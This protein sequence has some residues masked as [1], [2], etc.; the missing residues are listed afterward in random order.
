[1]SPAYRLQ[2][3]INMSCPAFFFLE[4]PLLQTDIHYL[5][6]Q[7]PSIFD[8]LEYTAIFDMHNKTMMVD[9]IY[10]SHYPI[11]LTDEYLLM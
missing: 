1:V 8:I 6:S 3:Q 4:V 5:S 10:L 9:G 7:G 11:F 2:E